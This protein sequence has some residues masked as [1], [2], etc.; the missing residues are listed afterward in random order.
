M[1]FSRTYRYKTPLLAE[2]IKKRLVGTHVKVHDMDFEVTE[3]DHFIRVIPHAEDMTELKTLPI[4]HVRFQGAGD[5]TQV[6]IKSKMRRIDV[7]GP[8]MVVI[9]CGFLF[10]A[11]LLFLVF[12]SDEHLTMTYTLGGI[13]LLIFLIFW[14]RLEKGYFDYVRKIR[15]YIKSQTKA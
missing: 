14:F 6:V 10:A 5:K 4:T 2:V 1:I 8:M 11:S 9:F 12:G 13:A 15:D 7:G 3:K